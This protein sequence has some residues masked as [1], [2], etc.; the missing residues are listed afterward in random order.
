MQGG[1]AG[2]GVLPKDCLW[3]RMSQGE[4]QICHVVRPAPRMSET[5]DARSIST[6]ILAELVMNQFFRSQ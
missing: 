6:R 2:P 4:E 3:E 1:I 5:K